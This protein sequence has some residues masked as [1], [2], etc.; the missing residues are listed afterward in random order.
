MIVKMIVGV[1]AKNAAPSARIITHNLY[2]SFFI[3]EISG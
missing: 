1:V 3:L 2:V